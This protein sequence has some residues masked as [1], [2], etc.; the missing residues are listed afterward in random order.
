MA[1]RSLRLPALIAIAATLAPASAWAH[2]GLGTTSGF[3]HGLMHPISGIDHVLAMVA[4]GMFAANLGGRALWAVP[5]TFVAIMAFGGL[6]GIEHVALPYAEIGIAS[7]VIV[8]GLI[9]ALQV[10]WPVAAAMGV[11]ALFAIFH[12]HAHGSEMPLSAS[13]ATYAAGFLLATALLHA[14]GIGL[15]R[16]NPLYA[17]R[18]AQLGG[19]AMALAGVGLLAGVI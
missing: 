14:V 9:V 16:M 4:V 18:T 1:L 11:V 5:A 8:L 7:S 19:A 10:Q 15:Q 2:V 12:G 13:G 17:R 3:S 6:L